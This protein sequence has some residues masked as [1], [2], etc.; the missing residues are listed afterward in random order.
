MII[1]YSSTK[2]YQS[3]LDLSDGTSIEYQRVISD[4]ITFLKEKGI[5]TKE[6]IRPE[7]YK[8]EIAFHQLPGFRTKSVHIVCRPIQEIRILKGAYNIGIILESPQKK[9]IK[10]EFRSVLPDQIKMLLLM[11]EIWLISKNILKDLNRIG[12][13]NLRLISNGKFTQSKL[14]NN[15]FKDNHQDGDEIDFDTINSR[16]LEIDSLKFVDQ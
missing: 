10:K 11:D 15:P 7:I 16:I 5:H 8:H 4:V 13:P 2:N 12:V 3:A 9:P 1:F 6:L 14:K